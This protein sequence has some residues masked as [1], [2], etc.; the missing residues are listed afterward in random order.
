MPQSR[1]DEATGWN[2]MPSRD[3]S[4]AGHG[5]D[6]RERGERHAGAEDAGTARS[7]GAECP[8]ARRIIDAV[9]AHGA[10]PVLRFE[11][12]ATPAGRHRKDEALRNADRSEN[13]PFPDVGWRPAR[14][15]RRRE[16]GHH[17][18]PQPPARDRED[19]GDSRRSAAR[20][21]WPGR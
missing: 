14:S 9:P 3:E 20:A 2:V 13:T 12:E 16:P 17:L 10:E 21:M 8:T 11:E 6:L 1:S 15:L 4:Q 19:D 5:R 7:I 18:P